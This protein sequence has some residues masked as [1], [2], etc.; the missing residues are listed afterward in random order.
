MKNFLLIFS[1]FFISMSFGQ[2]FKA[3]SIFINN[4]LESYKWNKRILLFIANDRDVALIK[5]VNNF[6]ITNKCKNEERNLELLK[7]IKDNTKHII[8]PNYYENKKGIWLIGYDGYIKAYT[9]DASLLSKLHN[10]IDNMPIREEE[11]ERI[12]SN[13]LI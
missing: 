12:K 9:K 4:I 7:I 5:E 1:L 6:F 13:C 3:K 10:L 8:I 2:E 11:L